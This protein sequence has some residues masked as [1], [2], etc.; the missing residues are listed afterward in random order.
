MNV[1]AEYLAELIHAQ[2]ENRK[3]LSIPEELSV[4]ELIKLSA[5]NHMDY[6]LLGA[7]IR[8]DNLPEE[9]KSAVRNKVVRSVIHTS[10]QVA[11]LKKMEQRFEE[12]Q[13]AC[14]PMK[15]ARMKFFY[16]SPEMRE[17]SDV[18]ILVRD[19]CMDKAAA[20]LTDMGYEL[21]QAIKH[22]DI[23]QK[24]PHMVVE[25]HRAMYDKTVD[26][27]QYEYFK[28][29]SRAV[30]REGYSYIYDFTKEDFYIYM[31][32]H[33]AKHFYAMGCGIRN[34]VDIYVYRNKFGAEM[35]QLYLD[36][37]LK[38]LGLY[39]YTKHMEKLTNVWLSGEEGE[40]FYDQLFAYMLD[41]G[42]Y[43][44]DENGI[45]NKFC[46][47]KMKDKEVNRFQLKMWYWFPPLHYMAEYYPWLEDYRFLLPVAWIIRGFRGIVLKKGTYKRKMIKEIDQE[48]IKINQNIYHKM[49]LRFK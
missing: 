34:L 33:M 45:W 29:L 28:N 32:A 38:L 48:N 27:N 6:L 44:K 1:L 9:W 2:L 49:Q 14:Q 30:P 13:I 46:E 39:E 16:P 4:E 7:L 25:V 23:Y 15:G 24:K 10:V 20:E 22:H 47:E 36:K 31:I 35:D 40:E 42:I 18:D 5:R 19:E 11:E 8:T 37:E 12:K 17:M 21:S 41:S 43:G 3:P 26:Y